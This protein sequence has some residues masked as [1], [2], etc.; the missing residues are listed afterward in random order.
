MREYEIDGYNLILDQAVIK[1]DHAAILVDHFQVLLIRAR[2][3]GG[4]PA[5]E[6]RRPSQLRPGI[7]RIETCGIMG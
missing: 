2:Q 5:E 1:V 6:E 7:Q 4:P 3:P